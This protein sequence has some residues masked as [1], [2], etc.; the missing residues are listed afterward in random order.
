[1]LADTWELSPQSLRLTGQ[2]TVD[3]GRQGMVLAPCEILYRVEPLRGR[4]WLVRR[5]AEIGR[6]D[7]KPPTVEI[8]CTGIEGFQWLPPGATEPAL[9]ATGLL[10]R[11]FELQVVPPFPEP[12]VVVRC[13]R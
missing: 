7:N 2:A 9:E 12:P 13:A 8:V 11:F 6:I 3:A 10:P 4:P 1:E 5:V